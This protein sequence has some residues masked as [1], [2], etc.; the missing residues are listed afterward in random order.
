V[1]AVYGESDGA[2]RVRVL[3]YGDGSLIRE[4]PEA[5]MVV[6]SWE[7]NKGAITVHCNA[8]VERASVAFPEAT[9]GDLIPG[10]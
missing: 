6:C 9:V 3:K 1:L 4:P 5:Y 2:R 8:L 10:G 7:G